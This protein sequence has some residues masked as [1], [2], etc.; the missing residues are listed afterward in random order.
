MTEP[1]F[2]DCLTDA[3]FWS[4]FD[5]GVLQA[6][7]LPPEVFR[8]LER[9]APAYGCYLFAWPAGMPLPVPEEIAPSLLLLGR[10]SPH[11]AP[12][13]ALQTPMRTERVRSEIEAFCAR[14]RPEMPPEDGQIHVITLN[15]GIELRA[16]PYLEPRARDL[17][18]MS[19]PELE[20]YV[21]AILCLDEGNATA[22]AA[23][24]TH[25]SLKNSYDHAPPG[26][27]GRT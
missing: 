12:A 6:Y 23:A 27:P 19:M 24:N 18:A 1:L 8:R 20:A 25:A 3:Q 21:D 14:L 15:P 11:R 17:E 10:E 13:N 7:M 2:F 9:L 5:S 4:L 26:L 16:G 22:A